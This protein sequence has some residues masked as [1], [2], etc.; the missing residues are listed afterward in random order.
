[1]DRA[2]RVVDLTVLMIKRTLIQRIM[3]RTGILLWDRLSPILSALKPYVGVE[4]SGG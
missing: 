3:L 2:L 4:K 1:M